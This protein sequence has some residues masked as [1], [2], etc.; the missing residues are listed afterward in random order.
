M[1]VIHLGP[2][3]Y[4]SIVLVICMIIILLIN[5]IG[6]IFDC[7]YISVFAAIAQVNKYEIRS[8]LLMEAMDSVGVC[9][10]KSTAEVWAS[11]LKNRSAALQYSVMTEELKNK[12]EKQLETT[13]PNW[14]TGTSSPW[15]ESYDIVKAEESG[16]NRCIFLLNFSTMTSTGPAG[17]YKAELTIEQEGD[18]W[19]ITDISMDEG[20]YAFTGFDPSAK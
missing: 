1:K 5:L 9:D 7:K 10:A 13:F 8:E 6:Y 12:Y 3:K 20:L 18:F 2:K 15:V 11:G 16:K 19:R 14:V 4:L 17:D